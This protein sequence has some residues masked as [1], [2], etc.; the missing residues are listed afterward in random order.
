MQR[1]RESRCGY[2]RQK[3]NRPFVQ[4]QI[5]KT[6]ICNDDRSAEGSF[7]CCSLI[8]HRGVERKSINIGF[9]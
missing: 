7:P 1:E 3:A 5:F 6:T 9:N 8:R 2:G 4:D